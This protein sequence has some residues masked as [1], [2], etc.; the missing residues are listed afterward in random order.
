MKGMEEH[1]GFG[2]ILLV[3]GVVI[4]GIGLVWILA[5]SIPCLDRLPGD[6]RIEGEHYRFYFPG[7]LALLEPDHDP[8]ARGEVG[9]VHPAGGKK[10]VPTRPG[11]THGPCGQGGG[12]S[13]GS[14]ASGRRRPG[15]P[16][17]RV[18]ARSLSGKVP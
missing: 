10:N 6:V 12:A 9:L 13:A 4:A 8:V 7:S 3:V 1:A 15:S 2:W 14:G 5:P 16:R 11:R 18:F 17:Q